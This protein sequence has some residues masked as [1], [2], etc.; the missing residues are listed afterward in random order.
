MLLSLLV[1]GVL[2]E[3]LANA[4]DRAMAR[5]LLVLTALQILTVVAFGLAPGFLLPC[6][7]SGERG[8]L[9]G[10]RTRSR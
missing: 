2:L 9:A 7:R 5:L 4:S 10:S 1:S 8:R 3:R 6:S